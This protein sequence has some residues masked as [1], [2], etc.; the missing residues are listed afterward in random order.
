MLERQRV[1]TDAHRRDAGI[2]HQVVA[3]VV[4]HRGPRQRSPGA[5][6]ER[7]CPPRPMAGNAA[8][9]VSLSLRSRS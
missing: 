9:A 1:L 5:T 6:G 3:D 2:D 8:S 4:E 7:S